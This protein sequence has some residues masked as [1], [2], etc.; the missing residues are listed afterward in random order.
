MAA[1]AGEPGEGII[2]GTYPKAH[3]LPAG[4][5]LEDH[6]A[7]AP[8]MVWAEPGAAEAGGSWVAA[9]D[10][11]GSP[12]GHPGW[13]PGGPRIWLPGIGWATLPRTFWARKRPGE[14]GGGRSRRSA[15]DPGPPAGPA[16]RWARAPRGREPFR[17]SPLRQ[18]LWLGG[19]EAL[20]FRAA[21]KGPL[22]GACPSG[23]K[24]SA[25][26]SVTK[27]RRQGARCRPGRRSG[28]QQGRRRRLARPEGCAARWGSR[29]LWQGRSRGRG[30]PA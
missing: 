22:S 21:R 10:H 30:E 2:D 11:R 13:P 24:T 23:R 8:R 4:P 1:W 19:Q 9:Q 14:Q 12:G 28:H 27:L 26:L 25:G 3:S 6:P 7:H 29:C 17:P 15:E 5:H 16:A 18:E 20:L